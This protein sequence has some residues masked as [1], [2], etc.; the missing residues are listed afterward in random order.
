MGRRRRSPAFT[1][2]TQFSQLGPIS[3]VS[4]SIRGKEA[5]MGCVHAH[6][7]TPMHVH[8]HTHWGTAARAGVSGKHPWGEGGLLLD[9]VARLPGVPWVRG[10]RGAARESE[11]LATQAVTHGSYRSPS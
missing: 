10:H 7:C 8:T 1:L 3:P 11:R 6:T 9:A 4:E 2:T 5:Q